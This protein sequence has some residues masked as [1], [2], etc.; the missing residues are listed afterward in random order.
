MKRHHPHALLAVL[1]LVAWA[2]AATRETLSL[3]PGVEAQVE[4]PRDGVVVCRVTSPYQPGTM[5]VRIVAPDK[6]EPRERQRALVVLP[7][8]PGLGTRWGDALAAVREAAGRC[9]FAVVAPTF[10]QWPWGADHPTDPAVR[11]ESYVLKAVV[12]LAERLVPHEP[13]RRALL[14]FSKGGWAA[15]S[16]L[17]RHP[18]QFAAAAAWDAPLMMPAAKFGMAVVLPTQAAFEPW[19]IPT[20]LAEHADAVRGAKRLALLG[21]GNFRADHREAHALLERLG[22]PHDYADGPPRKHRWD[23][24]WVEEAVQALDRLLP[25]RE[26]GRGPVP[27]A[28]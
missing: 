10:A 24:G 14:G 17:L 7:V 27:S 4:E 11:Q 26:S 16:L 12:P 13:R 21:Y 9:G 5:L 15:W 22:V 25:A 3:G 20:L 19:R 6:L 28:K 1:L 8:E 23:S 18:D 2:R